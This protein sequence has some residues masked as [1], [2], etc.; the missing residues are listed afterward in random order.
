MDPAKSTQHGCSLVTDSK[1]E[2]TTLDGVYDG[3]YGESTPTM[4]VYVESP[5]KWVISE[6]RFTA[7]LPQYGDYGHY[8]YYGGQ[9]RNALSV[10]SLKFIQP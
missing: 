8:C 3:L 9:L 7:T 2:T 4:R 1:N 6:V 5:V 10:C